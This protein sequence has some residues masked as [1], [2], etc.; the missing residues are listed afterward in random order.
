[1]WTTATMKVCVVPVAMAFSAAS[2]SEAMKVT[3][4]RRKVGCLR[5]QDCIY[6]IL[7]VIN[8]RISETSSSQH[9]F[10]ITKN[11]QVF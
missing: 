2:V 7:F 1:M 6:Y 11:P 3:G 10:I 5:M 8:Y 9:L 4:V